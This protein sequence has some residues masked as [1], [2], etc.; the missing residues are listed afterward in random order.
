[1]DIYILNL[2]VLYLLLKVFIIKK[3][4]SKEKISGLD[5]FTDEV[6]QTLKKEIIVMQT[7]QKVTKEGILLTLI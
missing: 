4:K 3:K 6:Y 5:G 2:L 7:F 1:M